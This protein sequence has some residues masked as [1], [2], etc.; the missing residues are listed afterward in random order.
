MRNKEKHR[1][2]HL[3]WRK[4]NRDRWNAYCR[5]YRKTPK[6]RATAK[7]YVEANRERINARRRA[8]RQ[9]NS[10]AVRAKARRAAAIKRQRECER[11]KSD[12]AF[13]ATRKAKRREYRLTFEARKRGEIPLVLGRRERKSLDGFIAEARGQHLALI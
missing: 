12:P 4:R 10:Y 2:A 7:A 13:H 8:H 3:R 5:R 11:E 1:A 6:A 9:E